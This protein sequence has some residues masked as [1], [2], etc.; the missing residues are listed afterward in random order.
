MSSLIQVDV[1]LKKAQIDDLRK[2]SEE[3]R[4]NW[5]VWVVKDWS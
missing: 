5:V 1:V 3:D 2:K 4:K